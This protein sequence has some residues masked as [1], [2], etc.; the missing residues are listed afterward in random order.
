MEVMMEKQM[1]NALEKGDIKGLSDLLHHVEPTEESI[2]GNLDLMNRAYYAL[3][4]DVIDEVIKSKE[5]E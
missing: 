3:N 2:R 1:W 4:K 5:A